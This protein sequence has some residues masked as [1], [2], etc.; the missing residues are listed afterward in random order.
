MPFFISVKFFL[1]FPSSLSRNRPPLE[2]S[3]AGVRT[4]ALLETSSALRHS[5]G[6][7][8][9]FTS[10]R[11]PIARSSCESG[12][13][14]TYIH[15]VHVYYIYTYFFLFLVY[16]ACL[17]PRPQPRRVATPCTGAAFALYNDTATAW[18]ATSSREGKSYHGGHRTALGNFLFSVSC[19]VRMTLC[20]FFF[21]L[22]IHA[23]RRFKQKNPFLN[24]FFIFLRHA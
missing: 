15:D 18:M 17:T 20:T 11:F 23:R 2:Y 13:M 1:S 21:Y 5:G 22:P 10:F 7:G 12:R 4:Q 8:I 19:I 6:G 16:A 9:H 3:V 24:N 14:Y